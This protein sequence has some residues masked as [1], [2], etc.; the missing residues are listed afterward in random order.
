MFFFFLNGK[1]VA[2]KG[3]MIVGRSDI[4]CITEYYMYTSNLI[5][6]VFTVHG[7]PSWLLGFSCF[8][9]SKGTEVFSSGISTHIRIALL[10]LFLFDFRKA[11]CVGRGMS[12]SAHPTHCETSA[13]ITYT[14]LRGF[15]II[16]GGG[17]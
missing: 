15:L 3:G 14:P 17:D 9:R 2:V 13:S 1:A 7:S 12:M 5:C 11:C 8:V 4:I 6:F 10:H 16:V